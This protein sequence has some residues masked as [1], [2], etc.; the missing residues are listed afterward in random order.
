MTIH[1]VVGL[2]SVLTGGPSSYAVDRSE[3]RV[4]LENCGCSLPCLRDVN[5]TANLLFVK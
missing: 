1:T 4:R 3:S 5:I 2:R